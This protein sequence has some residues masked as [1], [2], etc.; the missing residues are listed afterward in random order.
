MKGFPFLKIFK[1][2][3][4]VWDFM[5]ISF[6]FRHFL[7]KVMLK[8][9]YWM[10]FYSYPY[11]TWDSHIIQSVR[12]LNCKLTSYILLRVF[13]Y[14]IIQNKRTFLIIWKDFL[15][16]KYPSY[17]YMSEIS[18]VLPFLYDIHWKGN[19]KPWYWMMYY[20]YPNFT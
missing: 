4:Y 14:N 18:L 19:A 13:P 2:Y 11:S 12:R 16:S 8:T 7:G 10:M 17:K 6:P 1:L 3:K 5:S 20:S 15:F 9:W